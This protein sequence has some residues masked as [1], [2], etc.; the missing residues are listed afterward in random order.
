VR[1]AQPA[2][3]LGRGDGVR[4]RDDRS[5]HERF[6]PAQPDDVV[7][8]DSY[9]DHRHHDNADRKQGD[10]PGVAAQVAQR[11]EESGAVEQR[12]EED[13]QHQVRVQLQLRDARDVADSDA[14][15]HEGDRVRHAQHARQHREARGAREQ[16]EH[17]QLQMLHA[18]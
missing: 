5:Q 1:R 13:Q 7:C 15:E 8:D 12:R 10:R 2:Q 4:G 11:G 17:D 9:D 6:G 16:A 14:A 3:D 18:P